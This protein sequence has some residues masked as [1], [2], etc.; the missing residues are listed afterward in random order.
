MK[1]L[2]APILLLSL[3]YS[4][5][6][7]S[8]DK[9]NADSVAKDTVAVQ[10]FGDTITPEGAVPVKEIS[11]RI[12]GKDSMPIK[13]EGK[14]VDVCQKKGCWMALDL[15]NDE[16]MRVTFRDYAFFV[17]K[18][19]SGKTAIVDGYAHVD[20]TTVEELRHYAADGGA[21]KDSLAK[22]TEPEVELSFEARGVII[23]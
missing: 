5:S 20:T 18:D 12:S 3:A 9:S 6:N 10:I 11:T 7:T 19:A 8:N 16:Y 21:S 23:K 17:P 13:L 4:C 22:I 15:G 14:I 2:L 1:N